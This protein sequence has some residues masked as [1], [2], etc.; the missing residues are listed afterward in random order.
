[1]VKRKKSRKAR[2]VTPVVTLLALLVFWELV[3]RLFSVPTFLVPPPSS[4]AMSLYEKRGLYVYHSAVTLYETTLGFILA[5]IFGMVAAAVIVVLPRL[6][7]IIMPVLLIAQIVPKVAVAP[8]LLIWFGY[9][10]L[11]KVLIAFLV[12]F[13]PIVVNG[14][15]GLTSVQTELI[16]LGRSLE[17]S[18]W[19]TFWKFR[20]PSAIPEV[21][22][23]MKVAM[24]L[25]IVGAVIGEF[26][27]GSSGLG[28]LI[29]VANQEADTAF[30]F[31]SIFLLSLMGLIL[32]VLVEFAE[33]VL[34]PWNDSTDVTAKAV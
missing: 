33:R 1:M 25:A 9:G 10:L 19:Q 20:M 16:D 26:V 27:G 24:T 22:S 21:L 29:M 34:T 32:Y 6:R 30:A 4:V 2:A 17:A 13:F 8:L 12:A 11:P 18:K 31:A 14:I 5:V 28:Y 3:C 15:S 7:D 23:G